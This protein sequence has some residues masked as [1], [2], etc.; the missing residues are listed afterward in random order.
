[1]LPQRRFP[2]GHG[3]FS[4]QSVRRN[5]AANRRGLARGPTRILTAGQFGPNADKYARQRRACASGA[6]LD[7][8]ARLASA[9]AP[10]RALD[11]GTGGGHVAYVLARHARKATAVDISSQMLAAVAAQ[12]RE[13]GLE[14]IETVAASAE[15]LPFDAATFYF[16]ASRFSAHHWRDLSAGLR[17]A[18]RVLRARA[19]AVFID[20]VSPG[21]ALAR[22]ASAKR[23]IAARPLACARSFPGRMDGG[24]DG[25]RVFRANLPDLAAAHGFRGMDPKRIA[26]PAPLAEAIRIL[27]QK[28]DAGTRAHFAIE[29]DGSFWLDAAMFEA[30]AVDGR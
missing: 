24:A 19:P 12:A 27:Q 14:N 28:A 8:L 3:G 17:Q 26:T 11:L 6:D 7:A 21:A 5:G 10:S 30:F 25:G 9:A 4:G 15:D 2:G 23:R 13:R 29:D 16:L 18:R 22:H 1:M 20:I